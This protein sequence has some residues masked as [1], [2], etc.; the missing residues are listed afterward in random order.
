MEHNNRLE[1]IW[2][3]VPAVVLAGLIIYG[4]ATW[5]DI[6]NPQAGA[7][8]EKTKEPLV[9]EVYAKQFAWSA[10]YGGSDNELGFAHVRMIGGTNTLGVDVDDEQSFDDVIT[11]ELHAAGK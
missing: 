7:T 11:N 5:S 4:L 10:R 2:T 6:M 9:V 8:A 3:I 1:F